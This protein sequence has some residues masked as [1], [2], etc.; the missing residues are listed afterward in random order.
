M[1]IA[2]N[3]DLIILAKNT[4]EELE[5][6]LQFMAY[7]SIEET[8]IEY[9]LCN[10]KYLTPEERAQEGRE[11]VAMLKMTPLDFLKAIQTVGVTY[12][13]IKALCEANAQVDMELRFCNHVYRGNPLLDQLASQFN[14]TSEQLD[15]LFKTY[16]E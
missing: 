13:Q 14:V 8:D 7:T 5:Q 9:Q 16:G 2:K 15:E 3:N 1:F 11:R 12:A 6:A 10:G 4:R